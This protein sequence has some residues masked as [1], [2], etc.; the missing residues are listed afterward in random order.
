[1]GELRYFRCASCGG[2][3][4][5]P[6]DRLGESPKCGRCKAALDAGGRPQHVDDEALD[7]LLPT[8]PVPV[9]VDFY[10][11]WCG[12]CQSLAPVLERLGQQNAGRLLVVKVDTDQDQRHASSL[13]VRG[14]PALYLFKDGKVVAQ[15][16]GARPLSELQRLV[17]P[18]VGA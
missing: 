2:M 12:P 8:S 14:I 7:R 4:R 10:A 5:V 1:M 9:L 15:A 13:G 11:D 6:V 18:H 17:G 3:N 16:T